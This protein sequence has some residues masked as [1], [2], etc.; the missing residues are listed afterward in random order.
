M[1]S[2]IDIGVS[3]SE[4]VEVT[5]TPQIQLST[6]YTRTYLS[7]DGVD[8]YVEVPYSS[9]FNNFTDA[10]SVMAWVKITGNQ[11]SQQTIIE[12]GDVKGFALA[13]TND[14]RIYPHL[15]TTAGWFALPIGSSTEMDT[16]QHVAFTYNGSALIGFLNG[17][18][19]G[20]LSVSGTI[21]NNDGNLNFGFYS[22]WQ[23]YFNGNID[24]T[25]IWNIELTE[26]QIQS[27]M[28]TS[29]SG[30]ETGLAAYWNFNEG[31]GTT[32]TDQAGNGN[33]GTI[34][35][36]SYATEGGIANYTSGSGGSTLTF[37]YTV[38]ARE[39]SSDLDYASTS[40][41]SLNSGTI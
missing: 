38:V 13:I 11:G 3:F 31:T 17:Q 4:P 22:N 12:N 36:A 2:T 14:L 23:N 10:I 37:N 21:E 39:V 5:G 25:S 8:D 6:G 20:S 19:I 18:E 26:S 15:K 40:A 29:P 28:S 33:N 41:L 24:E 35:G 7:F 30:T 27:Y 16:W 32:L 1:G 9:G 34:N